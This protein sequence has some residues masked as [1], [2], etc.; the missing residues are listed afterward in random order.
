MGL[1][2]EL[3]ESGKAARNYTRQN[4]GVWDFNPSSGAFAFPIVVRMW[5][6]DNQVISFTISSNTPMI[7][8]TGAQFAEPASVGPTCASCSPPFCNNGQV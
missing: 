7:I 5:S 6:F 4:Y 2:I 3:K 1:I 8:D